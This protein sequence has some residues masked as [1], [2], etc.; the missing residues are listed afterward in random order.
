MAGMIS[1]TNSIKTVKER[2]TVMPGEKKERKR[3]RKSIR[4]EI[5][6]Y[7]YKLHELLKQQHSL[8]CLVDTAL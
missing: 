1:A 4:L 8:C 7:F 3:E 2:R 6:F 5:Q